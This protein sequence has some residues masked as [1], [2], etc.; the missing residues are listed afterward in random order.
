M[1]NPL[2]YE[3]GLWRRGVR[4]VAGLDE[5]GRGPLA[6]PVVAAAVVL[7]EDVDLPGVTDSKLLTRDEREACFVRILDGATFVTVAAESHATI[8][9][10][11]ILAASLRAMSRCLRMLPEPAHHALVDGN[12]RVPTLVP[13][14]T[15]VEGDRRSLSIGAASIVAKVV[16]DRVMLAM[17]AKWPHYGFR[18]NMGYGTPEHLAAL[19]RHGPCRIHRRSFRPVPAERD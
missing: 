13:Q 4:L 15:L 12:Q 3:R 7:R 2:F 14:T 11:N 9:R 16:R 1:E 8:D 10:I 5:A 19:A 6:G 18:T 17:H